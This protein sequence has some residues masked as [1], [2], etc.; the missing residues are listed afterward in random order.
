LVRTAVRPFNHKSVAV[1][2]GFPATRLDAFDPWQ[3]AEQPDFN[4]TTEGLAMTTTSMPKAE[5]ER[6][7]VHGE[8]SVAEIAAALGE[9]E[10]AVWLALH[11]LT[12]AQC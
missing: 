3:T 9:D 7:I 12:K 5:T 6:L 2:G 4:L 8:T 10:R 11:Q 1:T